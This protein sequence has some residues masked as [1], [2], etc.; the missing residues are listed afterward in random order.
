M[1]EGLGKTPEYPSGTYAYFLSSDASGRLAFPYLLGGQYFGRISREEL[2]QAFIDHLDPAKQPIPRSNCQTLLSLTKAGQ[3]PLQLQVAGTELV[4]GA[5]LRLSFQAQNSQQRPIQ[6]LEYVHERPLHLLIVSDDLA[7]FEHI[8]PELVAGDRYEITHTFKSGG[9]YRL[10]AD[11]TPPG[12][13][14]RVESFDLTLR[15]QQRVAVKLAADKNWESETKGVKVAMTAR[16]P[17]RAGEDIELSFA[18]RDKTT[19]KVPENLTPYLG[20]WAHF[21]LIDEALQSFIHAHPIETQSNVGA[22]NPIHIH[23]ESASSQGPPPAEIRVLTSFPKAGLY[24]LWAQFQL[25]DAVIAQPFVLQVKEAATP[26][27]TKVTIP[28]DAISI[29]VG[30]SGFAPARLELSANKPV[31][32]AITRDKE[33][34]CGNRIVFPALGIARDLPLGETVIVALPALPA[35]EL[36]FTCGMGMYKGALVIH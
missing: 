31:K 20:A 9:R 28:T 22:T 24:K 15:G 35:G 10:Y 21:V 25:G 16:Q 5:P 23:N 19:G 13:A 36:R 2:S 14:Q 29:K 18:I 11:F 26:S 32:L 30:A 17:L 7:E 1:R 8:H 33:P 3:T 12:G 6:F 4:A 27:L 34:N